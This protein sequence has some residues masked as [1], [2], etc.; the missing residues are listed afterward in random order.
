M[1]QGR[2]F[3]IS[4][5]VTVKNKLERL[6]FLAHE[7][8]ARAAVIVSGNVDGVDFLFGDVVAV[9][10][11]DVGVPVH[12]VLVEKKSYS[13]PALFVMSYFSPLDFEFSANRKVP[14]TNQSWNLFFI[15]CLENILVIFNLK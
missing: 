9:P 6:S 12:P 2:I 8:E 15:N 11:R 1:F 3:E 10:L 4:Y 7:G 13:S 5:H 14:Q